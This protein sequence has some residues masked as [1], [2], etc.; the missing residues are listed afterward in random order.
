MPEDDPGRV[1]YLQCVLGAVTC[2]LICWVAFLA[3]GPVAGLLAGLMSAFYGV[4]IYYDGILMPSALVLG[5]HMSATLILLAAARRRSPGWWIAGGLAVGLCALAHGTALLF[6][7]GVLVWLWFGFP[8]L[9]ARTRLRW[10]GIVA[11]TCVAVIS[12]ASIRNYVVADDFVLL[13]SN[14]GKNFFIGNNELATGT[15]GDAA[16]R[17]YDRIWGSNLSYYIGDRARGAA[18]MPPSQMSGLFAGKA[19]DFVL[20]NPGRAVLL[21]FRKARLCLNAVEIGINDNYYFARRYSRALRAA[22]LG[23]GLIAPVGLVGLVCLG[24]RWRKHLLL[25][26]LFVSQFA[27]FTMTFVLGR[28]R[29]TL[30]AVLIVFA[31]LQLCRWASQL[32]ARQY[33]RVLPSLVALAAFALIVNLPLQ[34]ITRDRGFGQ[35]Y[36]QVASA[37]LRAGDLEAAREAFAAGTTASFEPWHDANVRRAECHMNLGRIYEYSRQMQR[38]REEYR[39]AM[40]ALREGPVDNPRMVTWLAERLAGEGELPSQQRGSNSPTGRNE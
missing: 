33:R 23:F 31:S 30:A 3:G 25:I 24:R 10:A 26:V 16:T 15:F 39:Q 18:D 27:A 7:L 22:F 12:V 36:A 35:Q 32:R 40:S 17:P 19:R 11:V 5:L 4:F 21:L 29:L 14:A 13:T 8:E 1:R 9:P 34:G 2:V 20:H 38:A 6:L 28:Y 37:H